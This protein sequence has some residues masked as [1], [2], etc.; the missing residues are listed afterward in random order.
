ME[1]FLFLAIGLVAGW[2]AGEYVKN[3]GFSMTTEIVIGL[4]AALVGGY[5]FDYMGWNAYGLWG[6]VAYAIILTAVALF[7]TKL[8]RPAVP[9]GRRYE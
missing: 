9:G 4:F 8:Y 7:L 5:F 6:S 2:I 3:Y 1:I